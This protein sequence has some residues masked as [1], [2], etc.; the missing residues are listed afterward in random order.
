[1]IDK[2]FDYYTYD[3]DGKYVHIL[4]LDACLESIKARFD[5]L[6][7]IIKSQKQLLS[8]EK[9]D[10][11]DDEISDLRRRLD[12]SFEVT[13]KQWEKI[14]IWQKEHNKKHSYPDGSCYKYVFYPMSMGTYGS[15]ICALCEEEFDI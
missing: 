1:M 12:N 6:E 13:D 15:C 11:A 5:D 3:K 4:P 10:I 9:Y 2:N 14:R 7:G 8:Q